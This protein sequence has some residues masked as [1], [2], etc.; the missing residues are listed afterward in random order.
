MKRFICYSLIL[1]GIL[2]SRNF[3]YADHDKSCKNLHGKVTGVTENGIIVGDNMYKV[4][5]ST[6]VTKDDK[7]VKLESISTGDLVCVDTRGK[8][9]IGGAEVAAVA[10]LVPATPPTRE[11]TREKVIVQQVAHDRT[12]N[13][14]HGKVTRIEDT[15]IIVE[16]K[17]HTWTTT[18]VVKK[19][20]QL[21]KFEKVKRGDFV[22]LDEKDA[23]VTS[24]VVLSPTEAAPFQSKE[25]IRER[26]R[27]EK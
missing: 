18:T 27:E 8:D 12:C 17:P 5:N 7:V 26:I 24:L 22:C 25:I 16:G 2:A 1:V 21:A 15:T 9:D 3:A 11:I 23:K 4:G 13:H 6:R 14:I 20:G 10:V 19:D